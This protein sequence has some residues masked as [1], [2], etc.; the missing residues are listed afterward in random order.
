M[1]SQQQ[2]VCDSSTLA[3]FKQWAKAISDFFATAG[4]VKAA[5]TGQVD[6]TSIVAVPGANAY[7]YEVWKPGDALAVFYVKVEYGNI[8][9]AN[10]P[11]V[12][13][14][15]ATS[16][17]GAGV[18]TGFNCG[19]IGCVQTAYTAPGTT[20]YEC[21]FSGANNRIGIMLWRNGPN[22]CQQFFA[23][24]RSL[25]ASGNPTAS[26][27]TMWLVG[28]GVNSVQGPWQQTL[29][30][31]V[32]SVPPNTAARVNSSYGWNVRVPNFNGAQLAFNNSIPF[33]LCAPCIGYFDYPCT[34]AGSISIPDVTEG[35]TFQ[36][37]VYG[38]VRTYLPSKNGFFMAVGNPTN[39]Q[40]LGMLCM[41]YD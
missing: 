17:N 3:N 23:I 30:F 27:A 5:D 18:I 9:N 21:N 8:T 13:I 14:S 35:V 37:T 41:R 24:E 6:W 10:C 25:D 7:V 39:S 22:N 11:N 33:D 4:W 16:T 32:G 36:T 26:Y 29:L 28:N 19:P 40:N 15:L 12:R 34:V 38:A 20:Q 2:L 31:G 1:T